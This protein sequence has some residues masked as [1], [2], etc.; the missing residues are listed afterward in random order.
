MSQTE[1][2][3]KA[4]VIVILGGGAESRGAHAAE[5]YHQEYTSQL[6]VSGDDESSAYGVDVV[7]Q[8]DVPEDAIIVNDQATSTYDEAGQV[9]DILLDIEA[10][11]ALIVTNAFHTRRTR[12]TYAHVFRDHD[13]TLTIVAS[14]VDE[15]NANNWWRTTRAS[16][17]AAEYP[18]M[19]YYWLVYGIWSG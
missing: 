10:D 15:I 11:S 19:L 5:L 9:L 4:D 6:I 14:D 2:P 12:A 1:P 18:K 7:L 17:I 13:I 16:S 8:Y 3:E